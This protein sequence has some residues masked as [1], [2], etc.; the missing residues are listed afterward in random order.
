MSTL[1]FDKTGNAVSLKASLSRKQPWK[2]C[3][4]PSKV[5]AIAHATMTLLLVASL[6]L[7]LKDKRK[8]CIPLHESALKTRKF[9]DELRQASFCMLRAIAASLQVMRGIKKWCELLHS[10]TASVELLIV[11]LPIVL[12]LL[13][14]LLLFLQL[15]ELFLLA[16]TLLFT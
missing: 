11:A 6:R 12:I 15:V 1:P 2:R 13:I 8:D 10:K 4:A 3:N 14:L 5:L 7:S 16:A 9:E